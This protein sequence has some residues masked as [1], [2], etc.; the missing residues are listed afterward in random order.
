[1]TKGG[2]KNNLSTSCPPNSCFFDDDGAIITFGLSLFFDREQRSERGPRSVLVVLLL[3]TLRIK[4]V[5]RLMFTNGHYQMST[6]VHKC[7]QMSTS[8]RKCPLMSN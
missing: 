1:M 4:T 2:M 3:E 6:N 5:K 8:A 7:P